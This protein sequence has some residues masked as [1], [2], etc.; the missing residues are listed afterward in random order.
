MEAEETL[1]KIQEAELLEKLRLVSEARARID[2]ERARIYAEAK[3][4]GEEKAKLET[5]KLDKVEIQAEEK[6][7]LE[8]ELAVRAKLE[9]EQDERVIKSFNVTDFVS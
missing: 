8:A 4:E 6:A 1:L 5:E 9:S 3:A 7:R 2:A